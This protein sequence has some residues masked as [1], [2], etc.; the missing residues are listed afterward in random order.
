MAAS[1]TEIKAY[2]L[3]S[4]RGLNWH[5]FFFNEQLDWQGL[6]GKW[7]GVRFCFDEQERGKMDVWGC[8]F[9]I[10]LDLAAMGPHERVHFVVGS[11]GVPTLDLLHL[12]TQRSWGY[13]FFFSFFL[14][15]AFNLDLETIHKRPLSP[16]P[17]RRGFSRASQW[18]I[19]NANLVGKLVIFSLEC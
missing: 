16:N 4:G 19:L 14:K 6:T 8:F 9:L 17:L 18:T 12:V 10:L 5:I 13:P 2:F 15:K 3:N 1:T 7:Q 11:M